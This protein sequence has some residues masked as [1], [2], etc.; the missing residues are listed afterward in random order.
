MLYASYPTTKSHNKRKIPIKI[1]PIKR[2]QLETS[3]LHHRIKVTNTLISHL[4]IFWAFL[5]IET[6]KRECGRREMK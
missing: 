4:S 3:K 2:L 1:S 5:V 6:M